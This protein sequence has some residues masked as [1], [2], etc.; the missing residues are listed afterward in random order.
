MSNVAAMDLI[1]LVVFVVGGRGHEHGKMVV[2]FCWSPIY[3]RAIE[4]CSHRHQVRMLMMGT[5]S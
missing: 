3:L 4:G 2:L 1:E 5:F